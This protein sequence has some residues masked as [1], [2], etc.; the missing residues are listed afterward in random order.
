MH[1]AVYAEFRR[2]LAPLDLSGPVLEIGAT[3]TPDTLLAMDLLRGRERYG[4]NIAPAAMIDGCQIMQGNGNDLSIFKDGYFACVVSN[5]TIEHDPY[6]WKTCAEIR[7]VLRPGGAAVIGAP[8][9][10]DEG[11]LPA[12]GLSAPAN[13][14]ASEDW[15]Y[16][17]LTYRYHGEPKDYYR[18]SQDAFRD[19]IFEG[20][21]DVT[22]RTVLVPPRY[23][24]C[25]VK[26]T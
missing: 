13:S 23:I 21:R 19:V 6:F 17:T 24:G 18:F 5:A 12:L 1:S 2:L 7:R 15:P 22:I 16:S 10:S 11:N 4:I 3:P 26:P 25:G 14:P 9:F 8:G 20:Y